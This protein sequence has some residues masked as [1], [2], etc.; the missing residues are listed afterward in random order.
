VAVNTGQHFPTYRPAYRETYYRDRRQGGG[1][2]QD[3]LTHMGNAVEWVVGPTT[4]IFCDGAHQALEGVTVEDTVNA[5]ARNGD[6][7]VNY[8]LN[9]FQAPNETRLD[10]HAE[11][12]SVRVELNVQRWGVFVHGSGDWTWNA[13]PLRDRDQLFV[14]QANAFLDGCGGKPQEVCTIEEGL[15]TLRFNCAALQSL[16]EGR[17]FDL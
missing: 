2:I 7:L 4:R 14:S 16:L 12:G 11:G 9:Q 3:A 5:S 8:S 13:A 17:S 10:F 1:A 15:Q 6:V